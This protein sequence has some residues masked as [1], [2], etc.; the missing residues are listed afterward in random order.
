M[1][2]KANNIIRISASLDSNFFKYWLIILRPSHKLTDKE[3]DI[4]ACF[5]KHRQE[6]SSKIVDEELLDQVLMSEDV[7]RKVQQECNMPS[8]YFQVMLSKF[9]KKGV[10]VNGKLNKKFIP[11][12][13][14][15]E[16]SYRLLFLFDLNNKSDVTNL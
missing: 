13:R 14:G 12:L 1:S 10:I 11:R 8:Q 9:K 2:L 6:L 4:V 3:I 5:L 7:K 15:E 16:N